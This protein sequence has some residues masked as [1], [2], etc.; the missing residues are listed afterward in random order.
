MGSESLHGDAY[1]PNLAK[2]P[3]NQYWIG[4]MREEAS[5][6]DNLFSLFNSSHVLSKWDQVFNLTSGYRRDADITRPFMTKE[7]LY[8][9]TR[10]SKDGKTRT[11]FIKMVKL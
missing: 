5:Y 11:S 1:L 9:R 4:W 2:R 3:R 10:F 6:H 8:L 7:Q